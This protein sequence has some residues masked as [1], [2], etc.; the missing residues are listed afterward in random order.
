MVPDGA[1]AH[2][3]RELLLIQIGSIDKSTQWLIE[4]T[5]LEDDDWIACFRSL[6]E[7][8]LKS[9]IL[10]NS[11]FDYVVIFKDLGIKVENMHDTFLMS[12][13]LNTG[14]EL[15]RGYHSLAGCLKRFLDIDMDKSSQTTFTRD[16]LSAEQITYAADDVV[17]MYELFCKLKELLESW[18]LWYLYDEVERKVV[19]S[20][21]DMELS[22][23][24]FDSEYWNKLVD[25]LE[26]EDQKIE[27]ELNTF[28]F[29]DPK[30]VK[31]LENSALVLKTALIQPTDEFTASWGSN[32]V[33][34]DILTKLVPELSTVSKFTK[35]ELKKFY[36]ACSIDP[37]K[38]KLLN[39]YLERKYEVLNRYMVMYYK[40][41]LLD[42]E[43]FVPKGKVNINWGSPLQKLFIFNFYYPALQKTAAKFLA[44]ITANP[45]INKYK[46]YSKV[47]KYCTTYGANFQEKYVKRDQTIAPSGLNQILST[48]RI[49]YSIL[50]QMPG[51][52]RFRNGFLPPH[53]DWV[54]VDSD[55]ASAEL[56]I[57]AD[58]AGE[59]SLIDV[60]KNGQDAHMHV[61]QKLFP[62]EWSDAADEGC[63]Q[64]TTG[65][66][67]N[68]AGHN[69]LRKSGKAFNFGIPF[70]MTHVGLADRLDKSK[71]EA[72][73]IM[74]DYFKNFPALKV[75]FDE[76]Q[77][78]GE[79]NNHIIGASH[80]NRIRFFHPPTNNSEKQAIGR[81]A[82]NLKMQECNASMLKIALVTLRDYIVANN[83]PAEL[84]LPV[85][86]E[87]LSSC[88]KDYTEEWV[89]VQEK[90]MEDAADLFIEPGLL[91]VDTEIMD[92]WTK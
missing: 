44:R 32:I 69:K 15:G 29:T 2:D 43:Y 79:T 28:I 48:G 80:T 31:Y 50:L 19:K 91:K 35:P 1:N 30:L 59:Q 77:K 70:G 85:H 41:W 39:C 81:E 62:I 38:K 51:Q 56:A 25:E 12:K 11:K 17:H 8:K 75:F 60:I 92:R 40:P 84:H 7:N 16:P 37:V 22:P 86:D 82:K 83:F 49:A 26:T 73:L 10:H 53:K 42:K 18:N 64:M 61:A 52:A 72:K 36:K 88:H 24:K 58:L 87:I 71:D 6:F 21:C 9:F 68:C 23:M 4:W 20:Y 78:F 33:R 74:D 89:K 47:H 76:A 54:F 63:V 66:K 90:A 5:M 57:M 55:Y 45:I 34:K 3:D 13:I 14:L 27:K 67:C 46:E 65:I